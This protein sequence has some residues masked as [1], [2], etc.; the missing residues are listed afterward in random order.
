MLPSGFVGDVR[1][2]C[3]ACGVG[4]HASVLPDGHCGEIDNGQGVLRH[5]LG[6]LL[7]YLLLAGLGELWL[8]PKVKPFAFRVKGGLVAAWDA[9]LPAGRLSFPSRS[10]I[11]DIK[12][13]VP[14]LRVDTPHENVAV[15]ASLDVGHALPRIVDI[16]V[17]C[18]LLSPDGCHP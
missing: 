8:D 10:H 14:F 4:I 16:V 3:R 17:H 6:L 9:D 7:V 1:L 15:I 12:S 11:P 18:L 5:V 2:G 13:S